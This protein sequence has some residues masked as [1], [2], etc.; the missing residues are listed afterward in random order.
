MAAYARVPAREPA[1]AGP[2][3]QGA[4]DRRHRLL[5]R[6]GGLAGPARTTVLPCAAGAAAPTAARCA[7]GW[8]GCSTGEEAYSLAIAVHGGR[9]RAAG[10]ATLHAADLRH[11]PRAG[12]HRPRARTG[13]YPAGHRRRRRRRERLAR[14]FAERRDGYRVE[15]ARSARW[16]CS[17]QHDVIM[18][19]PFTR[20]DILCCRNL[21]IYF[22]A[23]LQKTPGAAVPLQPAPRRHPAAGQLGD[24][25]PRAGDCSRR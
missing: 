9:R 20:L 17:R 12:R 1:G 24:G 18:D 25:R 3:V 14:F 22:D 23:A 10:A 5:P 6:S 16:C 7:R 11:R 13:I 15:Q 2:A 4:A 19:P 8:P 21:L